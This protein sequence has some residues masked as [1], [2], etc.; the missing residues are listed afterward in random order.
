MT[1]VSGQLVQYEHIAFTGFKD[2]YDNI[3]CVVDVPEFGKIVGAVFTK[4]IDGNNIDRT[5]RVN[6]ISRQQ[7]TWRVKSY[8]ALMLSHV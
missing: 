3:R 8:D 5:D 6:G 2:T 4:I 7:Q 1:T